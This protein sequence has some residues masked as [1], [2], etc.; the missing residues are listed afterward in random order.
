MGRG[1][2]IGPL[3]RLRTSISVADATGD[4]RA[5]TGA[6]YIMKCRYTARYVAVAAIEIVSEPVDYVI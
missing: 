2:A 4:R 3:F 5:T 6:I 1:I